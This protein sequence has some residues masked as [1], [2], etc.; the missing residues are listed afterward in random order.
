MSRRG[1]NSGY[2]FA[3]KK[4]RSL[5]KHHIKPIINGGSNDR[6]NLAW[7]D[8]KCHDTVRLQPHIPWT[9]KFRSF[10]WQEEGQTE[11]D[12]YLTN[13]EDYGVCFMAEHGMSF[14]V[15]QIGREV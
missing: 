7:L 6:I 13:P 2:C 14:E 5:E 4:Y 11:H 9:R 1:K 8:W 15:K 3:C 10:Y 12:F